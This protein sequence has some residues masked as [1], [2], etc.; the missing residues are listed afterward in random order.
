ML[1]SRFT[2]LARL[3]SILLRHGTA[4]GLDRADTLRRAGLSE[5]DLANP[6]ARLSAGSILRLWK[7]IIEL[8]PDKAIG[9][10]LA[11]TVSLR[12]YGLVGYAMYFSR[13]LRS[14]FQRLVRYGHILSEALEMSLTEGS[15]TT[16]LVAQVM[17][18][19][20]DALRHPVDSRLATIVMGAREITKTRIVPE[21]VWFPYARPD[22]LD[23]HKAFFGSRLEFG[24]PVPMVVLRTADLDLPVAASDES[25]LG[26]LDLL[27]HDVLRSLA[28]EGSAQDQLY[29]VLL[30]HLSGGQPT[31]QQCAK[32]LGLGARTIQRRL[33]EEKTSFSEV[34][35]RLRSKVAIN[36]LEDPSHSIGD[37]AFFLGYSE[38][39]AFHRAF[40]R[41][42]GKAPLQYRRS[43]MREA[44][45]EAA[46]Q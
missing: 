3:R 28:Q 44:T 23:E 13:D 41:W 43:R 7:I 22:K 15:S 17:N 20:I 30:R 8:E 34:L 40:R 26:Y 35:D 18:P 11:Q 16:K 6:D 39:S 4:K 33:K 14:A 31:L 42:T 25:L 29:R 46:G 38:P 1:E 21:E 2:S 5:Q 37:V 24:K 27:A 19:N 12:D 32:D 45:G 9:I 10:R 36:L